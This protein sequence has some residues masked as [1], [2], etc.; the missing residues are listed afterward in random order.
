[1]PVSRVSGAKVI[2]GVTKLDTTNTTIKDTLLELNSGAGSNA[3]DCGLIIERGSTGDNATI[4]WDESEDKFAFGTT[5]ATADSTGNVSYTQAGLLASSMGIGTVVAPAS[6]VEIFNTN[7]QYSA[8]TASQSSTVIT[9]SGT[10]FTEA[11]V[12]SRFIFDDGT[13]AGIITAFATGTQIVVSTSQTVSSGNYKIYY[14]SVQIATESSSTTIKLGDIT[15][16]TEDIN[17]GLHGDFTVNAQEDIILSADGGNITMND[18]TTTIFDFDVDNVSLKIMDDAD[19]GDYFN[20]AVGANGAT[21]LSTVDDDGAIANMTLDI[22]GYIQMQ[23]SY[24]WLNPDT[25]TSSG[26]SDSSFVIQETLNLSSGAGGSDIHY[27]LLY[28]Q[29]QTDLTGWDNVYLMYLTGGAGKILSVDNNANLALSNDR[30]VIFGDAGEYISGDGTDLTITS[31]GVTNVSSDFTIA[32]TKKLYFDGGNDTYFVE[33]GGGDRIDIHVG[34]DNMMR[35]LEDGAT[36]GNIV[37]FLTSGV[38]FTQFEPTYNATDTY[39]YFQRNGN[40]AHLTFTSAS[41][42]ITDIHL[43]FPNASCNCVLLIKQHASGGGAVTNWKTFDQAGGN[44]STVVWAGDSAPTLTTGGGKI[45]IL[46]FYWDNDNHKAYG[47]ASLNF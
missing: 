13:D 36:N 2:A 1:M 34:G 33:H 17:L 15:I 10:T 41:E 6:K 5:S 27:G 21:I 47:V 32:N 9:G 11:M 38:G 24:L 42:T 22:D 7:V 12:G 3:N 40:K 39:V 19:T 4:L 29:T 37:N 46:S 44:E 28:E 14:P 25:K 23:G 18:G 43:H 16:G 8:G 35:L 26:T 31:S 20:I 45:D 30:K